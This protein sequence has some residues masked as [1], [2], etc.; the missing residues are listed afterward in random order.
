MPTRRNIVEKIEVRCFLPKPVVDV[1]DGMIKDGTYSTRS[2][3]VRSLIRA[4]LQ[5]CIGLLKPRE[6]V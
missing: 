4:H 5:D 1:I 3:A 2:E 6:A